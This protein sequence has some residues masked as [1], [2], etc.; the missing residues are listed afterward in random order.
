MIG[1]GL[2]LRGKTPQERE[3]PA[4]PRAGDLIDADGLWRV[5]QVVLSTAGADVYAI[6]A[7]DEV[8]A[9]LATWQDGAPVT[10]PEAKQAE[11]FQ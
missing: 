2:H 9:E 6:P 8:A 11:L 1:V 5:A 10:E 7:A 4:L 3:F